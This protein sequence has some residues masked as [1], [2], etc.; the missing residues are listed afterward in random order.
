MKLYYSILFKDHPFKN[1]LELMTELGSIHHNLSLSIQKLAENTIK[2]HYNKFDDIEKLDIQNAILSMNYLADKQMEF[3]GLIRTLYFDYVRKGE[4]PPA[5]ITHELQQIGKYIQ[6]LD[7]IKMNLPFIKV[8]EKYDIPRRKE[9]W[10]RS[11]QKQKNWPLDS[12]HIRRGI[13]G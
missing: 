3:V 2:R 7:V 8:I 13:M 11:Y 4:K 1:V 12:K 10:R 5:K 6:N 9:K